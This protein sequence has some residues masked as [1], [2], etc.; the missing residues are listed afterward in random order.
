MHSPRRHI[1]VSDLIT[2]LDHRQLHRDV[3]AVVIDIDWGDK[4]PGAG[5]AAA[6]RT[7]GWATAKALCTFDRLRRCAFAA[8]FATSDHV[9]C[10]LPMSHSHCCVA[11]NLAPQ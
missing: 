9:L 1:C 7:G 11:F 5:H 10:I 4:S 2:Y 8:T 6:G 3:A